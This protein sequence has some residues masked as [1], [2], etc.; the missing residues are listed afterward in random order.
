[1]RKPWSQGHIR[2]DD[3]FCK[4]NASGTWP[5]SFVYQL[6]VCLHCRMAAT[7]WPTESEIF[8]ISFI[9]EKVCWLLLYNQVRWEFLMNKQQLRK[10][11][12]L[13]KFTVRKLPS[14]TLTQSWPSV[15][16]TWSFCF[17]CT[18]TPVGDQVPTQAWYF[19][20]WISFIIMISNYFALFSRSAPSDFSLP[21]LLHLLP[22]SQWASLKWPGAFTVSKHIF[23]FFVPYFHFMISLLQ[24]NTLSASW[25]PASSFRNPALTV[26]SKVSSLPTWT[27][28]LRPVDLALMIGSLGYAL[29]GLSCLLKEVINLLRVRTACAPRPGRLYRSHGDM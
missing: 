20:P 15:Q 19:P 9:T 14:S 24:M 17:Y 29:I 12:S 8:T 11:Q 1:M 13:V 6:S 25:D 26:Y 16:C 7:I 2:L 22:L 28:V 27:A 10:I 21:F 4:W 3:W 23:C 18:A 5:C